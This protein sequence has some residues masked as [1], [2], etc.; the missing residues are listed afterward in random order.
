MDARAWRER[1]YGCGGGDVYDAIERAEVRREKAVMS[2]WAEDQ[3]CQSL[4]C[5]RG[6][7]GKGFEERVLDRLDQAAE[8]G[9]KGVLVVGGGG[10]DVVGCGSC[11]GAEWRYGWPFGGIVVGR[12]VLLV[13]D[14]RFLAGAFAWL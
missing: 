13:R 10:G 3:F 1:V 12:C 2:F 14:L 4:N 9:G 11:G 5:V 8:F 7:N 6:M